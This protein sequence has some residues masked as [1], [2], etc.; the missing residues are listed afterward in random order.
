L[1]DSDWKQADEYFDKVLDIDPEYA[2]AYV[3]KLCT[4]LRLCNEELLSDSEK[5]I[6]EL[7]NFQKAIRFSGAEQK[8]KLNGYDQKIK[9]RIQQKQYNRLVQAKNEA[10]TENAYQDLAK[11]L[12]DMSGYENTEELANEC[13]N[14]CRIL[15]ERREE[16]ERI[17][18]EYRLEA[19]RKK[20][21]EGLYKKTYSEQLELQ[22]QIKAI[23]DS[24]RE[25]RTAL[26]ENPDDKKY[27]QKC[28]RDDEKRIQLCE[29]ALKRL[30][31][32]PQFSDFLKQHS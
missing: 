29:K 9:E 13:D 20:R 11:Q 8:T 23:Q 21:I 31:P 15:K 5:P 28:I 16:Q 17:A 19:E 6:S 4:E 12:R 3:G 14:Q 24:M 25:L 10:S 18:S 26:K 2:S 7:S 1:E 27:I 22:R 32:P 30:P